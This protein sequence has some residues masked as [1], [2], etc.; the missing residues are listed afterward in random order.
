MFLQFNVSLLSQEEVGAVREHAVDGRMLISDEPAHARVAGSV[1]MLRANDGILVTANLT[2]EHQAVCSRCLKEVAL[3][4][5]LAIQEEFALTIDLR[6]GTM[7][8]PPDDP[9]V[10]RV[11]EHHVLDLEEAVR[12]AWM[13]ALP[14]QPLCREGCRGLCPECGQDLNEKAC[15]CSPAPDERWSGLRELAKELKG[16]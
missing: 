13:S 9:D 4:L 3:P 1:T 6:S 10:F 14:I 12:Q 15:S 11:D 8:P 2:G 7:L 16:T 5:E